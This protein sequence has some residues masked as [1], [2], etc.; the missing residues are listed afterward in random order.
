M[1][2]TIL[3][4]VNFILYVKKATESI[5]GLRFY[6]GCTGIV[7]EVAQNSKIRLGT[8]HDERACDITDAVVC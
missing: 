7:Q 5:S 4:S 8:H 6:V 2:E 1:K 3:R